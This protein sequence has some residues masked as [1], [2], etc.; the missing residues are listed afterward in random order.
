MYSGNLILWKSV[1]Y[2]KYNQSAVSRLGSQKAWWRM[3]MHWH[4]RGIYNPLDSAWLPWFR[5]L[6]IIVCKCSPLHCFQHM[7]KYRIDLR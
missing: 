1:N 2:E 6:V 5:K 3:R 7:Y 4:H